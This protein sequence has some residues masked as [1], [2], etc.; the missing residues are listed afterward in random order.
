MMAGLVILGTATALLCVGSHIALWIIGRLLQGSS[1]A[2]IWAVGCALLA[3]SVERG[4]VGK[5]FSFVGVALTLGYLVGPL[6]GGVLYEQRGYYSIFGLAF[7]LIGVDLVFRLAII[8]R[9]DAL[10]WTQAS[11]GAGQ[12]KETG[13]PA[14]SVCLSENVQS[15]GDGDGDLQR[16]EPRDGGNHERG[17]DQAFQRK[18]PRPIWLLLSSPRMWV[19]LCAYAVVAILVGAFDSVLPLFVQDTFGWA[20]TAQGLTFLAISLPHVL[21]PVVGII[22]DRY[23][24]SR[25]YLAGAAFLVSTPVCVCLRFVTTSSIGDK[26]LLCAL[27]AILGSCMS[28]METPLITE[29]FYIISEM[30]AQAPAALGEKGATAL[31]YGLMSSAFAAGTLVGPILAGFIRDVAGWGTMS[32]VLGLLTGVTAVPVLFSLGGFPGRLSFRQA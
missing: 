7:A 27:V 16:P 32:W 28:F 10:K 13:M 1:A 14:H 23:E 5:A 25:R 18:G 19:A 21:D 20:Q 29:I 30:E 15:P 31:A 8:E 11:N 12:D 17:R 6:V 4:Q 24:T 3:D 26:V 9:K 2:V 22:N